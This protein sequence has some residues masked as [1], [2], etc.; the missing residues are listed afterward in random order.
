MRL[1]LFDDLFHP[2][3]W[4]RRRRSPAL[5]ALRDRDLVDLGITRT[6]IGDRLVHAPVDVCND[7]V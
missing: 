7:R 5:E 2:A 1:T 4:P 3:Q 6:M